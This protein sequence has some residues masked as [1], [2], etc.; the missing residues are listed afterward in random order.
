MQPTTLFISLNDPN[1]DKK[2][3]L[4]TD[5]KT[6]TTPNV[7]SGNASQT[8]IKNT[9]ILLDWLI[10]KFDAN[11]ESA[12]K[13]HLYQVLINLEKH[14]T[15]KYALCFLFEVLPHI[16]DNTSKAKYTKIYLKHY[17]LQLILC[18]PCYQLLCI[19]GFTK[20]EDGKHFIWE[21]NNNTMKLLSIVNS[22]IKYY[23]ESQHK[24]LMT[25][26]KENNQMLSEQRMTK[27]IMGKLIE[28]ECDIIEIVEALDH[29]T[30]NNRALG[31]EEL[32]Q[33]INRDE[34][35]KKLRYQQ[36]INA[37][38]K[39]KHYVVSDC[40][41]SVKA[42]CG[43]T[44]RV[45]DALKHYNTLNL[46][47][48]HQDKSMRYFETNTTFLDDYIHF[49]TTHNGEVYDI[50]AKESEYSMTA[51]NL[52][53]C[54]I[55]KRYYGGMKKTEI[56]KLDE[57]VAFYR[58]TMDSCHCYIYHMYD[59]G[60]RMNNHI[61]RDKTTDVVEDLLH[62]MI[63]EIDTFIAVQYAQEE[64][65]QMQQLIK[66]KS[67][68]CK[69]NQI[70]LDRYEHKK[71]ILNVDEGPNGIFLHLHPSNCSMTICNVFLGEQMKHLWTDYTLI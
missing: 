26:Q 53:D 5:T 34:P 68:Q 38:Y 3:I 12:S 21:C 33:Y 40:A 62:E 42:R 65:W 29:F 13:K 10:D 57:N 58:D 4:E 39:S 25:E 56:S 11:H 36:S 16:L 59:L 48:D 51:C 24:Q 23:F 43:H 14:S 22:S 1:D 55:L 67:E 52:S 49:N 69:L 19:A 6:D 15:C 32:L 60:L 70:Y 64:F 54:S 28:Y 50:F 44:N 63:Q 47:D 31:V 61:G 17:Q 35:F 27:Q 18:K 20:T 46:D 41:G 30:N 45:I 2:E 8:Y 71:F 66:E 7:N 9:K 37:A